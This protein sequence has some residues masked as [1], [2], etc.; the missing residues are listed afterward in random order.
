MFRFL[1]LFICTLILAS[2]SFAYERTITAEWTA[3]TP[4]QGAT[5][6]GFKLYKD[7]VLA[8]PF[9]GAA[10]VK[11]EC[12]VDLVKASTP[13]TLTAVFSDGKESP[14]SA[15]FTLV[16]YGPGPQGLKL[17]VVTIRTVSTLTKYGNVIAKTTMTREEVPEG[18]TVKQGVRPGYRNSR[19]EYVTNTTIALLP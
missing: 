14:H 16:D 3:Y 12:T 15:P 18:T 9:S 1:S 8:C 17:T 13:F 2:S 19:G 4:P 5:T 10:I 11:G 6:T 7:G